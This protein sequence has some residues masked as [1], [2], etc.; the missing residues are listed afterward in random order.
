LGTSGTV[1][2]RHADRRTLE[3]QKTA[4]QRQAGG[5]STDTVSYFIL[6]YFEGGRRKAEF[7]TLMAVK[8]ALLAYGTMQYLCYLRTKIIDLHSMI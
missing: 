3:Q 1:F 2:T 5:N 7:T 6:I 8:G 4:E